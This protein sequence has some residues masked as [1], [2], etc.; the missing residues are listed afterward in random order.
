MAEIAVVGSWHSVTSFKTN[1]TGFVSMT[2][3]QN[4]YIFDESYFPSVKEATPV[5]T[6]IPEIYFMHLFMS[7]LAFE[8]VRN[9]YIK[10]KN[11]YSRDTCTQL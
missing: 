9:E 2:L 11:Q 4:T 1:F 5:F 6:T 3:S 7:D 10:P 8:L